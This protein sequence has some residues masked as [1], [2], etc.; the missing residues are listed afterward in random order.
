MDEKPAFDPSQPFQP[1]AAD[2]PIFD[3]SKPFDAAPAA[4]KTEQAPLSAA[5]VAKGA[6][7]NIPSSA[8]EFGRNIV[9][10]FIHPI[11]TVT[12]LK[13]IGQGVLEKTGL[14]EGDE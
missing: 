3:P 2:K 6:V 13:N 12:G 8:M 9:Q 10:P 1:A 14:M 11:D 5:D 4:A 7:T